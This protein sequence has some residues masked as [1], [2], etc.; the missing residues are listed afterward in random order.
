MI[1][2]DAGNSRFDT[3]LKMLLIAFVS[4]LAFSSGVYFGRE[5]T[6]ND[7][8]LKALESDFQDT[9][10][11]VASAEKQD[12]YS[13]EEEDAIGSE[14]VE[15]LA[16]KVINEQSAA[17][18]AEVAMAPT[19]AEETVV[20]KKTEQRKVASEQTAA[21]AKPVVKMPESKP[22]VV[23]PKK[24]A[25][26]KP[27]LKQVQEA[28]KRVAQNET[29]S[30]PVK[31]VESRVPQ[32]LPKSVGSAKETEYTV[33]VASYPSLEEAKAH[34]NTL[35]GKGFPAYPV[36]AKVKGKAWYRVSVGSFKSM[37][38]ASTYRTDLMKQANLSSA[39]VQKI[40]RQ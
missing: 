11:Q 32:S 26:A 19:A 5:M 38:E 28:A 37:K 25:S 34:A 21:A 40:D 6:E 35:V 20:E 2:H 10:T 31:E 1:T 18:K 24:T 9:H 7:Y 16:Q 17:N 23:A 13:L 14:E 29:P 22:E 15:A 27:D 36:E 4:L 33:Q 8:K 30:A 39:I 12:D 3:V